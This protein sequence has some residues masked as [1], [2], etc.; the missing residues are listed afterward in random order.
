MKTDLEADTYHL[1][2]VLW[3]VPRSNLIPSI[4][5]IAIKLL[6]IGQR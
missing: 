5:Q 4:K 6:T 2:D 3:S 1:L